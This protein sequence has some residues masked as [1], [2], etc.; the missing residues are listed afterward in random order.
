MLMPSWA[1]RRSVRH[2]ERPRG[3]TPHPVR[4]PSAS[5]A[6]LMDMILSDVIEQHVVPALPYDE[7]L[8][9]SQAAVLLGISRPTLVAW[10]ET[11]RL[12][13]QR[14]GT[15]RRVTRSDVLAYPDRLP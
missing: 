10:L 14:R 7:V 1:L 12:P 8:T 15:R 5:A 9:T 11:G 13:F 4:V 6:E 2:R 3:P